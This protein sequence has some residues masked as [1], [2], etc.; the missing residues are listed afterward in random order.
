MGAEMEWSITKF[1][2]VDFESD[3]SNNSDLF[4]SNQDTD[5]D[6]DGVVSGIEKIRQFLL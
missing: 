3:S 4:I 1:G 6:T 5:D 2:G